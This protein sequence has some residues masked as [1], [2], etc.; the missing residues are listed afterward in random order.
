VRYRMLDADVRWL[1]D[2]AQSN[3]WRGVV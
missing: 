2:R 3:A 1:I